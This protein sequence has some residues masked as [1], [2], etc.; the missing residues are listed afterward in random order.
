MLCLIF[1]SLFSPLIYA[2]PAS[3]NFVETV[4]YAVDH[5]PS[6]EVAKREAEIRPLERKNAFASFFPQLDLTATLGLND[7]EPVPL[8]NREINQLTLQL[9]ENFY[10]NGVSLLRH[11]SARKEEEIARLNFVWERDRLALSI[12]GEYLK[13]SFNIAMFEAQ[14][15]QNESLR[16]Q[17]NS[18]SAQYRQGMKTRR[19]YLRFR[20]ELRRSDLA[21]LNAENEVL[22]SRQE[23]ARLIGLD[24][25][26]PLPR[27]KPVP[28]N[29]REAEGMS[30]SAPDPTQH[31]AYRIRTLRL[32]VGENEVTTARRAWGPE[33]SLSAGATWGANDYIGTNRRLRDVEYTQWQAQLVFKFNL[34]DWGTRS[35]N[36]TIAQE[37]MLQAD[38]TV[39]NE[40]TRFT[41]EN[42]QLTK[43]FSKAKENFQMGREILDMENSAIG[44]LEAE[45]RNGRAS[46]LDLIESYR[47]L[48]EARRVLQEA[49]YDLKLLSYK[50]KYHEG[51]LYEHILQ[52]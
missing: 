52:E 19:D 25:S 37:K 1:M 2:A 8:P 42:V 29:R 35:R 49:Y 26:E 28:M 4:R 13:Y 21:V 12:A 40:L 7:A 23:I 43:D 22:K 31:I 38:A 16:K 47:T 46:Y 11:D 30:L 18:I 6:L 41:L 36:V 5:S 32:Q 20:A 39:R 27:F 24:V 10:D 3:F 33:I 50:F 15:T 44:T 51:R 14:K 9:T 45:Y 17:F 48:N 34:L